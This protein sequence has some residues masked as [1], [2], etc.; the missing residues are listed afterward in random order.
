VGI[1]PHVLDHETRSSREKAP[2]THRLGRWMNLRA[3]L[4]AVEKRNVL[5]LDVKKTPIPLS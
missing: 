5:I 3:C 1:T 4:D 2:G